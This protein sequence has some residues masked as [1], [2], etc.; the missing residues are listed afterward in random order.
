[1]VSG[2]RCPK[3]GLLKI[4]V[5]RV[6]RHPGPEALEIPHI[7]VVDAVAIKG[8]RPNHRQRPHPPS[9]WRTARPLT[10]R[11]H[12]LVN[13]VDGVVMEASL[14]SDPQQGLQGL[15]V[16][17]RQRDAQILRVVSHGSGQFRQ[18]HRVQSLPASGSDN[19]PCLPAIGK[20]RV[21][22]RV[23]QQVFPDVM[24]RSGHRRYDIQHRAVAE[25]LVL[26]PG[27][28]G[29]EACSGHVVKARVDQVKQGSGVRQQE[30][31]QFLVLRSQGQQLVNQ[32]FDVPPGRV[33]G[34]PHLIQWYQSFL[35]SSKMPAEHTKPPPR[36][37]V[38]LFDDKE[39]NHTKPA[40]SAESTYSFYDRSGLEEF[41]RLRQM[42]QRWVDRLPPEKAKDI[43]G[44]M[45]HKG[46]GSAIDN[47]HFYSAF[48]ELSLHEFLNGTNGDVDVDPLIDGLT[49]DFGVTETCLDGTKVR[50]VVEATDINTVHGTDMESNWDER[51]ALDVLNEIESPDYFLWVETEGTPTSTPSK[52]KLKRP[53]DDLVKAANYD[54]VRA[55]YDLHGLR[56]N[57]LPS[58]VFQ[59]GDWTIVGRLIPA[60]NRPKVGRFVGMGPGG[61]GGIDDTG[62]LKSRLYTKA[63]AYKN[64][65]NLIIALRVDEWLD[66]IGEALFGSMAYRWYVPTDPNYGGPVPES[67][68]VQLLDGFWCNSHGP[69]NK[70]V[71]GVVAFHTLH[72][73]CV[74]KASAVFFANPYVD[75][76]LPAWAKAIDHAE[77]D[78]SNGKI[79]IVRGFP[80]CTFFKDYVPWQ[81]VRWGH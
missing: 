8:R 73:H 3:S 33:G 11:I 53:F 9:P 31:R 34:E 26:Q 6:Q 75:K 58:A 60:M 25:I 74:D 37:S 77:Y 18:L 40:H 63:R 19:G 48:F 20:L 57:A 14:Q 17:G 42:L 36:G 2:C 79:Q 71:I 44:R 22:V 70:N 32:E 65:D 69:Q 23:V 41:A 49:P 55:K 35:R 7:L 39:R 80:P 43:V 59:H 76:P 56:E 66:D 62:K 4:G 50:Y 64:V 46:T 38:V 68:S 5:H 78:W 72:P 61:A 45:R 24:V 15:V 27:D 12:E 28:E 16:G 1:M 10:L 81:E 67:H 13:A 30:I 54:D 21:E 47:Q 52:W 29:V 51:N